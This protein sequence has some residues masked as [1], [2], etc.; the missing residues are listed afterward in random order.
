MTLAL[1]IIFLWIGRPEREN[2]TEFEAKLINYM[3]FCLY[4]IVPKVAPTVLTLLPL[5]LR[6]DNFVD[7]PEKT[8]S[9]TLFLSIV[10][11]YWALLFVTI[12]HVPGN[13]TVGKGVK[14]VINPDRQ[15]VHEEGLNFVPHEPQVEWQNSKGTH[16][17]SNSVYPSGQSV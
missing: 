2:V 15:F 3:T 12:E 1:T 5:I 13:P 6:L 9:I 8:E 16:P 4:K 17:L 11:R 7:V 14:Y 10:R